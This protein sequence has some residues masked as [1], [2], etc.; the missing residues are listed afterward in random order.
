MMRK[1]ASEAIEIALIDA[2]RRG[3]SANASAAKSERSTRSAASRL[4]IEA[5]AGVDGGASVRS[6]STV[7]GCS[8][9]SSNRITPSR[10][11]FAVSRF[12]SLEVVGAQQPRDPESAKPRDRALRHFPQRQIFYVDF[13]KQ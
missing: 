10:R 9:I 8:S 6:T 13:E 2:G 7:V 1:P 4:K 3:E 5:G 12:R 11:G